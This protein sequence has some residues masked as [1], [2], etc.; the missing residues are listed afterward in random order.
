MSHFKINQNCLPYSNVR[1]LHRL[2]YSENQPFEK[3][4][5]IE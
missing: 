1:S 2:M 4:I 3:Q 5:F